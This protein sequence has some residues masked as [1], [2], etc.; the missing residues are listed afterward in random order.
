MLTRFV[1]IDS[2]AGFGKGHRDRLLHQTI[3]NGGGADR[4]DAGGKACQDKYTHRLPLSQALVQAGRANAAVSMS[5]NV[6][7]TEPTRA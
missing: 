5:T 2:R 4:K 7:P 3:K 1:G 6:R